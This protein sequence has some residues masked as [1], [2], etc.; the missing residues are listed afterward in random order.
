MAGKPDTS[1][2]DLRAEVARLAER[3][4]RLQAAVGAAVDL[5]DAIDELGTRVEQLAS[6]L[7]EGYEPGPEPVAWVDV[8]IDRAPAVLADLAGWVSTVLAHHRVVGYL[9]PC[10]YRHPALVQVLLDGWAAWLHAY[11]DPAGGRVLPALDWSGRHLPHLEQQVRDQL[12]RCSSV[13][14]E[15]LSESVPAISEADLRAYAHWW[16]TDRTPAREPPPS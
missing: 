16:A 11:R 13:R 4:A 3:V 6:Q 9:H 7:T 15:P 14:H 12:G 1:L 8:G 10:W 5:A 2:S